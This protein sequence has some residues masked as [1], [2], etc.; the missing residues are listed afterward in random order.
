MKSKVSTDLEVLHEDNHLIAINK[1]PSDIVQGDKTGD[2]SLMEIIEDFLKK[3]YNKPG[4]AFVGL[5]HRI[6]RPV[7]GVVVYAK[8]SKCLSKMN[9][10]FDRKEV[11]KTYWAVVHNNP[12][13][14]A[15][16]LEHL[17]WK[18]KKK[19]KSFVTSKNSEKAKDAILEYKKIGESE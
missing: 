8:T 3:K 13:K 9:K 5:I 15:D 19:N 10:L 18:D 11:M 16:R 1:K 2:T 6:D 4:N 14:N 12:P 7:S 17:L